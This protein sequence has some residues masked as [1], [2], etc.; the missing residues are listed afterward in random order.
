MYRWSILSNT[1]YTFIVNFSK[2][3]KVGIV[4]KIR[5]NLSISITDFET[6]RNLNYIFNYTLLDIKHA[7]VLVVR[8]IMF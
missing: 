6:Y 5:I 3:P 4:L 1:C 8:V 2:F 7:N